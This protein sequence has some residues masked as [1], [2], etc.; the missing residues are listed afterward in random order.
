MSERKAQFG[1]SQIAYEDGYR[2]GQQAERERTLKAVDAIEEF[3]GEMPKDLA[4]YCGEFH[5]KALR[6]AVRLTKQEIKQAIQ[7]DTP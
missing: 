1:P 2:D 7:E 3:E 5:I 4:A 6:S